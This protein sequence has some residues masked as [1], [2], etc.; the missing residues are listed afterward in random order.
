MTTV[1]VPWPQSHKEAVEERV[2]GAENV[3]LDSLLGSIASSERMRKR[4]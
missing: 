2:L 3:V 4:R 1:R